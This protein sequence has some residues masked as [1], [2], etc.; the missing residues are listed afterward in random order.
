[1]KIWNTTTPRRITQMKVTTHVTHL[2]TAKGWKIQV[3]LSPAGNWR[4]IALGLPTVAGPVIDIEGS[5]RQRIPRINGKDRKIFEE[6]HSTDSDCEILG[7]GE[8]ISIFSSIAQQTRALPPFLQTRSRQKR[9]LNWP[10]YVCQL[11]LRRRSE[12]LVIT[13]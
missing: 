13:V 2:R 3:R 5:A 9:L 8:L 4:L 6:G 7:T 1:M 10:L 11:V 12:S